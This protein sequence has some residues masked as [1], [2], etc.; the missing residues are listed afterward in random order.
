MNRRPKD[1]LFIPYFMNVQAP[2]YLK[3]RYSSLGKGARETVKRVEGKS[4]KSVISNM[5]FCSTHLEALKVRTKTRVVKSVGL[6][7]ESRLPHLQPGD[8]SRVLPSSY[9]TSVRMEIVRG[10]FQ[11]NCHVSP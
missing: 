9:F 7:F 8:W 1:I 6:G 5:S 2:T 11:H 10:T 4:R 3:G